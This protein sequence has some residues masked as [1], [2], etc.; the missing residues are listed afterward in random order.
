MKI[1]NYLFNKHGLHDTVDLIVDG[2]FLNSV[3]FLFVDKNNFQMLEFL[4]ADIRISKQ[5][6]KNINKN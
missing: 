1:L 2:Y 3:T 6:L 4:N 5:Y